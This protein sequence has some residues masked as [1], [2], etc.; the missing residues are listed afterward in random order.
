MAE[1]TF[2]GSAFDAEGFLDL[3]RAPALGATLHDQYRDAEP[4]PHAVIDNFIDVSVLDACLGAFPDDK[5]KRAD[6]YRRSQENL[7]TTFNPDETHS[8]ARSLFYA[9]NS[10]PFL[11]FL[12]NLTGIKG[13]IPDPY[14]IGGGFHSTENGGH[15]AVHADFNLHRELGLERRINALIYLN[16]DW[17]ESYGGCLELWDRDM[18][19]C[20]VKVGP[21]FNRCVI[22]NTTSTSWHGHPDPVNHPDGTPRRSLALYYYTASWDDSRFAH[23]THFRARRGSRDSI[24]WRVYGVEAVR[25]LLPPVLYRAAARIKRGLF[26]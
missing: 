9:F 7:K 23:T 5:S 12:E 21:D 6:L 2:L 11:Q 15:L 3:E 18:K 20:S 13:L 22:F 24:D 4:F 14:F 19:A 10:A 17:E 1:S 8:S 16:R 26:G 25:D